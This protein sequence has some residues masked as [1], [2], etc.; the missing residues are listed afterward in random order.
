M[1][2]TRNGFAEPIENWSKLPNEFIERMHEI[3]TLGEMKVLLYVVRHTWGYHNTEK[4]IT[5]DEFAHGRK[6]RDGTRIDHGTGMSEPS[7]RGGI[8]MAVAHGF[9]SVETDDSDKGRIKKIYALNTANCTQGENN[10]HPTP[11]VSLPPSEKET[12]ERNNTA[13]TENEFALTPRQ[14]AESAEMELAWQEL[15]SA[16][17]AEPSQSRSSPLSPE[18][19]EEEYLFNKLK[20]ESEA[21]SRSAPRRFRTTAQRQAFRECVA[22]FNGATE[23]QIDDLVIKGKADLTAIV[24]GLIYRMKHPD[25]RYGT[26]TPAQP[27]V[28]EVIL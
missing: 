19:P 24:N 11:Q 28:Y 9:L 20:V 12:L 6:R 13:Q 4:K 25:P 26:H 16:N 15:E 27:Y 2:N 18:T 3:E 17:T 21:K 7:I 14:E 23:N 22:Y 10:L 8:K 1:L 5:M